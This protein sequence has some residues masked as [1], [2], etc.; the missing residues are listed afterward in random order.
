MNFFAKIVLKLSLIFYVLE[1]VRCSEMCWEEPMNSAVF[2]FDN[3]YNGNDFITDNIKYFNL[4][5]EIFGFFNWAERKMVSLN[6][7][8]CLRHGSC[9]DLLYTEDMTEENLMDLPSFRKSDC[10]ASYYTQSLLLV[11]ATLVNLVETPIF[12]KAK[13]ILDVVFTSY[14]N[15]G[16]FREPSEH[17]KYN[18]CIYE[19]DLIISSTLDLKEKG[20]YFLILIDPEEDFRHNETIVSQWNELFELMEGQVAYINLTN[21]VMGIPAKLVGTLQKVMRCH[22]NEPGRENDKH[23][24]RRMID[25]ATNE[26]AEYF[27]KVEEKLKPYVR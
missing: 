5:N 23:W 1:I 26:V 18:S 24:F 17:N 4:R 11:P 16:Y 13:V 15:S 9:Y 14:S 2:F 8:T 10:K 19:K 21:S 12:E 27:A 22:E 25:I 20:H 7:Y 6:H 3:D